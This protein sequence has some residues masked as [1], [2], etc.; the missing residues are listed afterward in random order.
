MS[1]KK[2][3]ATVETPVV[4]TPVVDQSTADKLE[5]AAFV[6]DV[7]SVVDASRDKL[8]LA[9]LAVMAKVEVGKLGKDTR[10]LFHRVTASIKMIT[11]ESVTNLLTDTLAAVDQ[12]SALTDGKLIIE[13][14]FN[15]LYRSSK[16]EAASYRDAIKDATEHPLHWGGFRLIREL[17]QGRAFTVGINNA[18][19]EIRDAIADQGTSEIW[20][21][22]VI[23]Q[24]VDA[25]QAAH[26]L[27]ASKRTI[28]TR[29]DGQDV[30]MFAH[31][32]GQ[33]VLGLQ[34]SK[35]QRGNRIRQFLDS[36]MPKR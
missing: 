13:F 17:L 28:C 34:E 26:R 19:Q 11:V 25:A 12:I 18:L 14:M 10:K 4:E 9:I 31:E 21:N 7:A 3:N 1:R 29:V 15:P 8:I 36:Y 20:N 23:V 27:L 16:A 2:K 33:F 5:Y 24:T 32:L 6:A 30:T 22:E 35:G